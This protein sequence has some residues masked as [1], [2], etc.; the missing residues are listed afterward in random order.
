[1]AIHSQ[2]H[3]RLEKFMRESVQSREIVGGIIGT[4]LGVALVKNTTSLMMYMGLGLITA[5]TLN[6]FVI[7]VF[8]GNA[9]SKMAYQDR[10]FKI[11][12]ASV[13]SAL[14]SLMI[15]IASWMSFDEFRQNNS[16][17][18]A[19]KQL[20]FQELQSHYP[21]QYKASPENSWTVGAIIV[22]AVVLGTLV[23]QSP[24]SSAK[25]DKH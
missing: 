24:R 13:V 6:A 25:T 2:D 9:I 20:F 22:L 17:S 21:N 23:C 14:Q 1:M 19:G 10:Q 18:E 15:A 8:V 7:A 3:E 4:F 12:N 5:T 11:T 16:I